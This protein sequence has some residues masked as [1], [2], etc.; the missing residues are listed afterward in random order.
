LR[1]VVA[2]DAPLFREGLVRLLREAGFTVVGQ[3][4]DVPAL[5]AAVDEHHPEV[6]LVDVR[7]PPDF[8]REG[9]AAALDIKACFP[10]IG[11]LVLSQYVESHY[12]LQLLR[13]D[14]RGVGYLLKERVASPL[15]LAA[16]VREVAHGGYVVD[17]L[18][19]EQLVARPRRWNRLDDLT[20]RELEVLA[21]MAEGRSNQ[22]VCQQ[23][24]LGAKTVE[25]HVRSI[26]EKLGLT[27]SPDDHRRVLA[28]LRYL[29]DH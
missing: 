20:P 28:V 18:V 7:M 9:L 15:E 16:A 26:F 5:M 11:V 22:A 27:A 4:G 13:D 19:I 10:E 6:A 8:Q 3:V 25:S 1:V 12:A 14:A 29:A 24:S 17:P 23:L 21:L 2:E